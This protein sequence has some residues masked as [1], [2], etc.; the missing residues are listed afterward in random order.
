[1]KDWD[2]IENQELKPHSEVEVAPE[3][4]HVREDQSKG[5]DTDISS[6]F[7]LSHRTADQENLVTKILFKEADSPGVKR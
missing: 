5:P 3:Q 6:K 2:E 1:M 7:D 4:E